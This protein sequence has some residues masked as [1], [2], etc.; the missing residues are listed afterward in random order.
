M[1]LVVRSLSVAGVVRDVSFRVD[2]AETVALIGPSGSGKTTL[3]NALAGFIQVDAG[4]VSVDGE[5]ITDV[6]VNERPTGM[7]LE[8]PALFDMPVADNIEFG[9]DDVRQSDKQRADMMSIMMSS[10]NIAGLA[11]KHPSQLSGGQAQRVALARTLVRRPRVL[12]LDEPLAHSESAV[13]FDI[14][15]EL[16]DHVRRLGLAVV[17]VTHDI[18][19][20][21]LVADRIVVVDN[22]TII[23]QGTPY[24]LFHSP[25]T[26]VVAR[27]MGVPNILSRDQLNIIDPGASGSAESYAITPSRIDLEPTINR[28]VFG[29]TGLIIRSVFARSHYVVDV[30]TEAGTLVVWSSMDLRVGEYYD[31]NVRHFCPLT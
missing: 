25:G 3:L 18:T 4:T 12:L 14:H 16:K 17:Y 30:E 11:H 22:G 10:F 27:L 9:L 5:E 2:D 19:D 8:R 7:M 15:R 26:A 29:K 31:V 1:S 23:Q 6:P 13:R 24:E 21:C 20:A 28:D